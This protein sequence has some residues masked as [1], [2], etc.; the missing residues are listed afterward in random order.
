M[1]YYDTMQ[2]CLK[3]HKITEMYS[4]S[5]RRQNFCDNCGKKTIT[6][7]PHCDASIRG[8]YHMDGVVSVSSTPIP[9]NCH[10]CGQAYP[11]RR[12][13]SLVKLLKMP[14]WLK[15]FGKWIGSN[16]VKVIISVAIAVITAVVLFKMGIKQ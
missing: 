15:P 6:E 5:T 13:I 12:R 16:L 11:W 14:K 1:S 2:V 8:Y 9:M 3:G 7:C 10:N 4:S